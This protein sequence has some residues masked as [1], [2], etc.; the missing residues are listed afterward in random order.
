MVDPEYRKTVK[1]DPEQFATSFHPS[2]YGIIEY[3]E[4]ILLPS[5]RNVDL[6]KL[7][8]ELYKLNVS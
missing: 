7:H 8:A 4:H 3:I 6:R 1:L 2:D 5:S